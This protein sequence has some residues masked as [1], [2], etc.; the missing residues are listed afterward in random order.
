MQN[1]FRMVGYGENLGSGFPLILNAW[2]EKHWLKPEL[3]EQPELM[4]VKLTLHVQPDPIND[5]INGPINGPIK[6][7]ER[8]ELIL[9]MFAEDKCLSI[10]RLCEKTGLSS[11]TA[12]REIAF[13]K[14]SGC[15]ERIGSLKTGYWKVNLRIPC[16][17]TGSSSN[18]VGKVW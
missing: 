13:L 2:N 4:Q 9:Q 10:G 11:T 7:T 15:L 14:K 18:S 12:K 3:Q 1:M 8:Q 16:P 5:P 17:V 6:L